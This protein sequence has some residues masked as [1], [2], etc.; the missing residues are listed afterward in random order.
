[1][2]I[3]KIYEDLSNQIDQIL[4]N[5][6]SKPKEKVDT[7]EKETNIELPAQKVSVD[8]NKVKD[9]IKPQVEIANSV[10]TAVTTIFANNCNQNSLYKT[11]AEQI[12]N[13][14]KTI[15]GA[16][17]QVVAVVGQSGFNT[18][19]VNR[20]SPKAYNIITNNDSRDRS[21]IDLAAAIIVFNNSL[22]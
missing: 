22:R 3:S 21:L 15:R 16:C 10:V 9:L 8:A 13:L 12:S 1:M 4:K 19:D 18:A 20:C 11:V 6:E 2:N 7:P 14:E 5:P 17:E